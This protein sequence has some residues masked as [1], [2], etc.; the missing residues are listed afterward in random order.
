MNDD[1]RYDYS[2]YADFLNMGMPFEDDFLEDDLDRLLE[3]D[4][5]LDRPFLPLRDL[6]LFPQMVMPL[7]VGR[8]RS[9]AA[10]Q[11]AVANGETLIVAAQEDSDVYEP[12]EGDIFRVGTE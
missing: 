12:A 1:D 2:H 10:V 5:L 6:V 9:L 7:F 11:A 3:E 8:E 4:G